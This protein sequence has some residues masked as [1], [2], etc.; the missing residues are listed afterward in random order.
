MNESRVGFEA[1][2]STLG[3]DWD[4]NGYQGEFDAVGEEDNLSLQLSQSRS[5]N[6]K[7]NEIFRFLETLA[8]KCIVTL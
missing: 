4:D 6:E 7:V 1:D 3:G 5:V 8:L 2:L